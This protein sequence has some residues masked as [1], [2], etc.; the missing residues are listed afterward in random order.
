MEDDP[1]TGVLETWTS[2]FAE[3]KNHSLA[4]AREE[5]KENAKFTQMDPELEEEDS[6]FE[7]LKLLINGNDGD[8]VAF[9]NAL[10]RKRLWKLLS[11]DSTP[12][13]QNPPSH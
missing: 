5:A 11:I 4:G 13:P 1:I 9:R 8:R 6:K 10:K 7:A 3:V 12:N 2:I